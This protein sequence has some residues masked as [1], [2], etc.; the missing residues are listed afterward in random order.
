MADA[1]E[2]IWAYETPDGDTGWLCDPTHGQATGSTEYLRADIAASQLAE[3]QKQLDELPSKALWDESRK[4][5]ASMRNEVGEL[6]RQLAV[7]RAERDTL[8]MHLEAKAI[9]A[10]RDNA[11][12]REALE[13][14]GKRC[15]EAVRPDD[16]DNDGVTIKTR[17]LRAARAALAGKE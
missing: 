12:L 13:P 10:K 11:R 7:A 14:F 5:L 15:D 8:A 1:P 17:Y 6:K 4:A 3:K 9:L 2:R 16:S